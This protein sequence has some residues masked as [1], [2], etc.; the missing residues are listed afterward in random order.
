MRALLS[1]VALALGTAAFIVGSG[2]ARA[3]SPEPA[4][5]VEKTFTDSAGV[6]HYAFDPAALP[7]Y[8]VVANKGQGV[9]GEC[10]FVGSGS[11]TA[12]E[13]SF[14]RA[15]ELSFDPAT[16]ERT[17]A[18]ATYPAAKVPTVVLGSTE[19]ATLVEAAAA[20]AS[21]TGYLKANVEDPPQLNVSSTRSTISWSA[22]SSCV[23]SSTRSPY[24]YWLS[25]TGWSRTS[26]STPSNGMN[27]AH[28]Y[29][30]TIGTFRND[31]FCPGSG[32][33]TYTN[34]SKTLFEGKPAG[35]YYWDY[36]MS[37]SGGCSSLLHY[38]YDLSTP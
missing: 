32:N 27:C 2:A 9:G 20:T 21:Y 23:T 35:G 36:A 3:A 31:A 15:T 5:S 8:R 19:R 6:V 22:T 16:C 24:W 38:D 11:G 17:L 28:A 34:H 4:V 37:K 30:N 12:G 7:G 18:V 14:T 33:T 26:G 29:L 10:E 13:P 25:G 1:G